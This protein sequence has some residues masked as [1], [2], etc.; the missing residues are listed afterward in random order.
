MKSLSALLR[1]IFEWVWR[2]GALARAR[3]H[4]RL[5]P[6]EQ[7]MLERALLAKQ[8]GDR[9][10]VGVE[11]IDPTEGARF[12]LGLYQQGLYWVLRLLYGTELGDKVEVVRVAACID[13]RQLT[14][15]GIAEADL[16]ALGRF[17]RDSDFLAH[18]AL[19]DTEARANAQR[20]LA[21]LTKLTTSLSH[22]EQSVRTVWKQRL[23]RV[24]AIVA[25]VIGMGYGALGSI[26]KWKIEKN[27]VALGKHWAASSAYG[28]ALRSGALDSSDSFFFHTLEEKDPWVMIDLGKVER[29]GGVLI[30]NRRDCCFARAV[31]L[32]VELSD[33]SHIWRTV[34]R[35]DK[36]FDTWRKDFPAQSARYLRVRAVRVTML[37]LSAIR[38][39][40]G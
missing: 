26:D 37:H 39:L 38:I 2:A 5:D 29:I 24:T 36:L 34:A 33:D 8:I 30:V 1:R 9:L 17:V 6:A 25:V 27:D 10:L 32:V 15:L 7:R 35:R 4:Q 21:F 18:F 22:R 19:S 31:P 12:A 11:P 20:A 40:R 16:G 13:P 3:G 23:V 14:A 28:D